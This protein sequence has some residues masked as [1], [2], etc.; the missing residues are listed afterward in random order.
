MGRDD[1]HA[2]L[3]LLQRNTRHNASALN[4][5]PAGHSMIAV[6]RSQERGLT[7]SVTA[8]HNPAVASTDLERQIH[9]HPV[10]FQIYGCVCEPNQNLLPTAQSVCTRSGLAR[11][12]RLGSGRTDVL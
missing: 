9:E 4:P 3:E 6:Q 5:A 11:K 10:L 2:P 8:M 7:R 1:T 12:S